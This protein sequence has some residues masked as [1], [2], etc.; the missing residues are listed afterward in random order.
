MHPTEC[1][2]RHDPAV[3]TVNFTGRYILAAT[4]DSVWQ[5]DGVTVIR[6]VDE[7]GEIW[8]C[9]GY[10]CQ[11]GQKVTLVMNSNSTTEN[12]FDDII[13]DVLYSVGNEVD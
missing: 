3:P 11:R 6:M 13:E 5:E 9:D 12:I 1:G 7:N 4:V 2:G 10:D 8:E